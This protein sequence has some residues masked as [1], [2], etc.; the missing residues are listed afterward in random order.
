MLS[1]TTLKKLVE[2]GLIRDAPNIAL[3][4]QPNGVE[5]TLSSVERFTGVGR[6]AFDNSERINAPTESIPFDEDGWVYLPQGA[7]VVRFNEVVSIPRGYGALAKPR[8]SLLRSG[9]TLHTAVWDAGYVGRGMS[10]L[11]VYNPHG[12]WLKRNARIVQ[13]VLFV[14]DEGA[15]EVYRGEYLGEGVE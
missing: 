3:Q 1:K 12:F 11:M 5:L 4:L 14:L 9:A 2:D 10:L 15:D 8:S 6:L 7:Y 13:L